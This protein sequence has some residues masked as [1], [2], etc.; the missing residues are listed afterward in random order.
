[1]KDEMQGK[2]VEILTSIQ[3]A[4]GKA[5]DFAMEQLPDITQ[6]YVAYGRVIETAQFLLC[7]IVLVAGAI[8]AFKMT[9]T[10]K[11]VDSYGYW[12]PQRVIFTVLGA[13]TSLVGVMGILIE[14]PQAVLVWVAPKVWLLKEIAGMLR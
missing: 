5:S 12:E 1:M 10:T 9:T 2:L 3:S 8:L 4:A 14:G 13:G 6:G 11:W 7:V